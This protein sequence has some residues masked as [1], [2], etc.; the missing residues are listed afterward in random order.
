[1]S[2]LAAL[3]ADLDEVKGKLQFA[4]GAQGEML[5]DFYLDQWLRDWLQPPKPALGGA[6]PIEPLGTQGRL[7]PC[8]ER[9]APCSAVH[10]SRPT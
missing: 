4:L 3:P 1:M 9:L 2:I 8:T 5:G 6:R 7:I 10:T